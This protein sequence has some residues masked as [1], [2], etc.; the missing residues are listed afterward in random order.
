MATTEQINANRENAKHSS[1][2]VSDAG[3]E[4]SSRNATR[5]GFTGLSIVVTPDERF[6][7]LAH[8]QS[9]IAQYEPADHQQE[10]LA[11]QLAD[12]EW[13][14]HQISVQQINTISLMN[15]VQVQCEGNGDPVGTAHVI[16][17]LARTLN[18]LNL[19]EVRRRRAAKAIKE[20]LESLIKSAEQLLAEQLP[21]AA[22]MYKFNK[23]KNQAWDPLEFGFVCSLEEIE[24]YLSA[25]G[26]VNGSKT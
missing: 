8:V 15:A 21:Q 23:A 3:K 18:N 16:A 24:L 25:G 4:T 6:A 17:S 11:H 2:P 22:A 12:L 5:H 9:C 13:S 19:Y 26:A 20:E 14:L 10:Q 1:G 7:Y